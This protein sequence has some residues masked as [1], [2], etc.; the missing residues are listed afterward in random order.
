MCVQCGCVCKRM[1]AVA[2]HNTH[3]R[4]SMYLGGNAGRYLSRAS[5]RAFPQG[6]G[7]ALG[8]AN[9]Q[10]ANVLVVCTQQE[11]WGLLWSQHQFTFLGGRPFNAMGK[12]PPPQPMDPRNKQPSAKGKRTVGGGIHVRYGP[13]ATQH[14]VQDVDTCACFN[15]LRWKKR[16]W[17][18]GP[19]VVL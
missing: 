16:F 12:S 7:M 15:I 10:M 4:F 11:C 6:R 1:H 2:K 18:S 19:V 13:V 14:Q 9:E 17:H 8:S 5:T 3:L